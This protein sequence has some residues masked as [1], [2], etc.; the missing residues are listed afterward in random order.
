[1]DKW[2]NLMSGAFGE[3][4]LL[5]IDVADHSQL[6]KDNPYEVFED[7]FDN[8]G[9]WVEQ[10][11]KNEKG[12]LWSWS[13]DGGL[14]AFFQGENITEKTQVAVRV[15]ESIL[16]DLPTF[17]DTHKFPSEKDTI[18]VRIAVHRGIARFKRITSQ[19]HSEDIN[20][21]SHLERSYTHPNSISISGE[22]YKEIKGT[23]D[24]RFV[25][26]GIFEGHQVYTTD[27]E[28]GGRFVT[29]FENNLFSEIRQGLESITTQLKP[30]LDPKRTVII[31]A[32]RSGAIFAGM[33]APNLEVRP[34]V[35]LN[36][37]EFNQPI[38]H[39]A[40]LTTPLNGSQYE[41]II[42]FF[43]IA[44]Q[45]TLKA[46]TKYLTSKGIKRY[47]IVAMYSPPAI[48]RRLRKDQQHPFLCAHEKDIVIGDD[49]WDRLPW[50]ITKYDHR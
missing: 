41:I 18:R 30:W 29:V 43:A 40:E 36:R 31:S 35:V 9:E 23:Y 12:Q 20:F 34:V 10:Y 37:P 47:R 46:L 38:G 8:F 39:F 13:G 33:L 5:K 1:M 3:F 42:V 2:A 26:A 19:I 7:I 15:A 4:A 25:L 6:V 16:S 32:N 17:N 49:F 44:A 11:I 21:V 50:I 48:A 28:R 45:E 27:K 22:A 24:R 14:A